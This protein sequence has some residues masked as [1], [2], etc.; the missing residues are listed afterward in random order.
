MNLRL[1]ALLALLVGS[2]SMGRPVNGAIVF[3]D[4]FN[5]YTDGNLVGQGGWVQLG[6]SVVNQV[7]VSSGSVVNLTTGQDV[8]KPFSSVVARAA[9]EANGEILVTEFDLNLSS[10]GDDDF[11]AHITVSPGN[12]TFFNRFY[13]QAG[14]A[15]GTFQLAVSASIVSGGVVNLNY[16]GDLL[17]G[18]TYHVQSRWDFLPG[19]LNDQFSLKIDGAPYVAPFAWDSG[20]AE[21][22]N[23]G[24]FNLRQGGGDAPGVASI[25]NVVVTHIVPEP[26]T[27]ALAAFAALGV[28]FVSTRRKG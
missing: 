14:T 27:F 13:S 9:G 4:D 17:L 25:D 21:S 11:F 18:Q 19:T 22:T 28:A 15:P 24:V 26:A 8:Q 23:L 16:G 12:T 10:A 1:A 6:S 7:Q 3:S 2:L 20:T 5:A